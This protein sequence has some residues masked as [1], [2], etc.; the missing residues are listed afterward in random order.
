M[1][2]V[3]SIDPCLLLMLAWDFFACKER[4]AKSLYKSKSACLSAAVPWRRIVVLFFD[5]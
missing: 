3:P 5:R 4:N 2:N 1:F